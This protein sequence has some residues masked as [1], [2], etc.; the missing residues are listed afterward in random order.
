MRKGD[1][2][3]RTKRINLQGIKYRARLCSLVNT[4][5]KTMSREGHSLY[6][7]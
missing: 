6:V 2:A 3:E 1:R 7:E 4:K 5:F